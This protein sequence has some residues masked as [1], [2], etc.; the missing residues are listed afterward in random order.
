MEEI[1]KKLQEQ[2]EKLNAIYKST[3]KTRKYFKWTLIL[4][5]VFFILPLIG[6]LIVIPQFLSTLGGG[7][8]L[9]R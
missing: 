1:L 8:D 5:I 7:A 9:L 6:L 4:S 3:E 2:E